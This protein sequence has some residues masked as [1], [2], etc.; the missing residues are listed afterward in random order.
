MTLQLSDAGSS[1]NP[2]Q[3]TAA[4]QNKIHAG[5]ESHSLS[6]THFTQCYTL[7]HTW[8][9]VGWQKLQK[10]GVFESETAFGKLNLY[11]N[12]PNVCFA[13]YHTVEKE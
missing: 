8:E 5:K 6:C 7:C 13:V 3:N 10:K 11:T 9:K 2:A 12:P 1:F 4:L